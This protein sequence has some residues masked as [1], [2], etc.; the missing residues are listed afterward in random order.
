MRDGKTYSPADY[1]WENRQKKFDGV[2]EGKKEELMK[3]TCHTSATP[4]HIFSA[5][6][7]FVP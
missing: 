2:R 1:E 6:L 3:E 5:K 4:P 7:L